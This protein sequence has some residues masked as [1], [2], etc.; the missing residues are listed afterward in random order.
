MAFDAVTQA[1][2]PSR[3]VTA[4]HLLRH[5]HVDTGG[6]RLCYGHTDYPLSARGRQDAAALI[7]HALDRLTP[8]EGVLS[9][10][11]RRCREVAEPLAAALGVPLVLSDAL[12]EQAMGAWEGMPWEEITASDPDRVHAYWADYLHTRPPGGESMA[13]LATRLDRWRAHAW[14][15]LRGRRW[16][17][18]THVGVIRVLACQL[19]GL[20]LDQALRFSPARASHSL[21]LLAEAGAVMEVFGERPA[22][23]GPGAPAEAHAW[24]PAP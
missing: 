6:R 2:L 19:L 3:E 4:L 23:L 24:E 12:R 18:V 8:P 7:R 13:D 16:V 1:A 14:P 10:D 15:D 5:P 9:S 17:V 22:P 21:F 20:P 11:L